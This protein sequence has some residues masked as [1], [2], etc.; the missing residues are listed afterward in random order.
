MFPRDSAGRNVPERHGIVS[1][2]VLRAIA[3]LMVVFGHAIGLVQHS[4]PTGSATLISTLRLPTGA[5]VD[6][7]FVISGFIMLTSS[8][9]LFAQPGARVEFMRRRLIR[10]APLYWAC[11]HRY[12][13]G[14]NLIKDVELP[15][16]AAVLAFYFFIPT[17]L[18][19][20][21]PQSHFR[22][23]ISDGRFTT[24]CSSMRFSRS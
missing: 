19:A 12:I 3:A 17:T 7:F 24:R 21:A 16:L 8:H 1:I 5:G 9:K 14:R 6:L 23:L 13:S 2:Q 4:S 18:G 10:I 11:T 22:C 20:S 15:S